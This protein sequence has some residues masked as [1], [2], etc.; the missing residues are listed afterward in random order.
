MSK[1]HLKDKEKA[2]MKNKKEA[3]IVLAKLGPVVVKINDTVGKVENQP[4]CLPVYMV[5]ALNACYVKMTRAKQ[6][7]E[8]VLKT[9]ESPEKDGLSFKTIFEDIAHADEHSQDAETML[10]IT[11]KRK[12]K[13]EA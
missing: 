2:T 7:F 5:E 6:V 13:A 4:G 1:R 11:K 10:Q 3:K 8:E 9:G 12:V